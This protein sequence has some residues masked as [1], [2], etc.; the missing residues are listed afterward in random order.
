[1][2]Q[3]ASSYSQI[4]KA[5]SIT[6]AAAIVTMVL[7]MAK[8][9]L[10]AVFIGAIGVGML[11]SLG[12]IQAL[13]IALAGLGIQPSAVRELA[14]AAGKGNT[15]DI[16]YI[17]IA[18][19]R[20]SWLTGILG[21]LIMLALTPIIGQLSFGGDVYNYEIAAFSVTILFVNL[22]GGYLAILQG[23]RQI[24]NMARVN[25]ISTFLGALIAAYFYIEFGLHGIVPSLIGASAIQLG[26][27]WYFTRNISVD[28]IGLSWP[29]VFG[30]FIGL[31]K[32][33]IVFMFN[34]LLGSAVAYIVV[35]L[36]IRNFGLEGAGLYGAAFAL[37]GLFVNFV[38]SAMSA[39]YYPR[40]SGVSHDKVSVNRMV[41]EQTEIGLLLALPGL[42]A[43]IALA[44]LIIQIFYA[45]VFM[46]AVEMLQWFVLG[47][48]GRVIAW[49]M[50]FLLLALNKGKLFLIIETFEKVQ[51]VLLILLGIKFFGLIGIGIAFSLNLFIYTI[52]ILVA[53]KK[54][55]GFYLS[56]YSKKLIL[57]SIFLSALTLALT[58]FA[59]KNL[60]EFL[61][62]CLALATGI[63]SFR[64]LHAVLPH[65]EISKIFRGKRF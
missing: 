33:G 40:I 57:L 23:M 53:T 42:L 45:E 1:M 58:I 43:T 63:Y 24:G 28:S 5:S 8:T 36:V 14:V 13:F 46:G 60:V 49:P 27:A 3:K 47:C 9:K 37:S 59:P 19:K 65:I 52:V 21:M 25:V 48:L 62:S 41:N 6:G 34:S 10:A 16:N 30:K 61:G 11:T 38:L 44:P 7:G 20:I 22:S 4:L 64:K 32:L 2:V 12:V 35:T 54:V 17:I 15:L 56:S 39:D 18:V 26:L 50:G 31:V 55:G 29:Q 51:H